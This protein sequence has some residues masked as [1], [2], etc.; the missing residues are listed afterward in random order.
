MKNI[1]I[2][3]GSGFIGRN[4][5]EQLAGSYQVFSPRHAELDLLNWR[6][7]AAY[8]R[9]NKIQAIVHG[10][11]HSPVNDMRAYFNDMQMFI[12]L[13]KI[14]GDVEKILYFGS[15]AEYD[16]RR[17]I[18]MIKEVQIGEEIPNSQ[19]GFAK[20]TMNELAKNSH[21]IYNLRLFGVFGKYESWESRFISNICCK[22]IMDFPL[23]IRKDCHFDYL[24]VNDL[25]RI[26]SWFIENKP[27]FHD[28][29]VCQGKEYLLSE[30]ANIV[31]QISGKRLPVILLS[32]EKNFDYSADNGRI[33]S[34]IK[35]LELTPMNEVVR[36]LYDY[37]LENINLIDKKVLMESR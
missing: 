7:V 17:D 21:N 6:D 15:G 11:V 20:Y 37:Y 12:N 18:R 30:L 35:N 27:L 14:S 33:C 32:N 16:K 24:Y 19:Y 23:T 4:L 13:E 1:M 25:S 8:I 26:V 31:L 22:A 28:Y 29:N 5:T 3:G 10:A 9:K 36:T 34:E 2:T